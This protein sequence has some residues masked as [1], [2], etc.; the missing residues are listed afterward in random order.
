MFLLSNGTR[1]ATESPFVFCAEHEQY[2]K[3]HE[4]S[5][6][7]HAQKTIEALIAYNKSLS[8]RLIMANPIGIIEFMVSIYLDFDD[9][10]LINNS[11]LAVLDTKAFKNLP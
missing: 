2:E 7:E 1:Y 6:F 8:S 3:K 4:D 9:I 10:Q 11:V 5:P